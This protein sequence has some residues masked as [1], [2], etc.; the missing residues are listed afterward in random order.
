MIS[1]GSL[2]DMLQYGF[3]VGFEGGVRPRESLSNHSSAVKFP[4]DIKKFLEKECGLGAMLGLFQE[5]PF[6]GWDRVN[7]LMSRPK[8]DSSERRLILD[9]SFPDGQ[10]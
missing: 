5:P 3:P 7:P 8:R 2:M 10:C 1:D 6:Q 9:L 4:S